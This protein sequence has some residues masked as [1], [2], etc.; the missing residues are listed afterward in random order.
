MTVPAGVVGYIH[1]ATAVLIPVP[2]KGGSPAY[3]N[4][5]HGAPMMKRHP[6]GT[7]IVF[8]MLTEDIGHLDA[9]RRLHRRYR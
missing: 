6:V 3:L 1:V 8:T 4:G 5:M 2:A 7:S 9:L